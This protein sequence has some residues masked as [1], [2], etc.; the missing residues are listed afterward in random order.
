MSVCSYCV[1]PICCF[2]S[3]MIKYPILLSAVLGLLSVHYSDEK[4]AAQ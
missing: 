2:S 1:A 3:H 4:E